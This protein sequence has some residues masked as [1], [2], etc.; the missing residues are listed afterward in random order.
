MGGGR[1]YLVSLYYVIATVA[2]VGFGDV[3]PDMAYE[4]I[5]ICFFIIFGVWIYT[6][7]ISLFSKISKDPLYHQF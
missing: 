7:A 5:F 2:T 1:E 6:N 4:K 3:T